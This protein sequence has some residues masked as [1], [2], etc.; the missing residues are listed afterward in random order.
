M[1][2]KIKNATHQDAGAGTISH[3]HL[4]RDAR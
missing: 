4:T 1:I 2:P 3:G